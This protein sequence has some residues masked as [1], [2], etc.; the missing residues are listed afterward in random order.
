MVALISEE[1]SGLQKSMEGVPWLA[2]PPEELAARKKKIEAK[3]PCTGYP[4]PGIVNAKTGKT[5]DAD[6]F[7]KTSSENFDRWLAACK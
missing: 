7:G 4:T 1:R 6:A 5:I 3:V 2:I